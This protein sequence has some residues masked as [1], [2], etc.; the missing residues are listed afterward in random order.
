[1]YPSDSFLS[2]MAGCWWSEPKVIAIATSGIVYETEDNDPISGFYR[3]L[4]NDRAARADSPFSI[5]GASAP[6]RL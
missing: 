1:M 2:L 5:S 6:V 4:P 3:Y